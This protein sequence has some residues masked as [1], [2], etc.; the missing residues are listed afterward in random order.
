MTQPILASLIAKPLFRA[1][2]VAAAVEH[3]DGLERVELDGQ[4]LEGE[5]LVHGAG[6][7]LPLGLNDEAVRPAARVIDDEVHAAALAVD[8]R[9]DVALGRED[10]LLKLLQGEEAGRADLLILL[11]QEVVD[12]VL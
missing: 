1:G 7:C 10:G 5:L 9:P 11:R 8:V 2:A 3:D 4:N 6:G 12:G